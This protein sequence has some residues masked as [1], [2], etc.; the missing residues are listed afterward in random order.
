MCRS[1]ILEEQE[2]VSLLLEGF[3]ER[4][5]PRYQSLL[6]LTPDSAKVLNNT[7]TCHLLLGNF[8][9][10]WEHYSRALRRAPYDADI[11]FNIALIY[12][13]NGEFERGWPLYESRLKKP[14]FVRHGEAFRQTLWM[15]EELNGDRILVHAEQGIGDTLQMVRL[16][17]EVVKRGGRVTL[18]VQPALRSLLENIDGAERVVSYNEKFPKCVWRCSL[19]SLPRRLNW[20]PR[21]AAQVP[22]VGQKFLEKGPRSNA[23]LRVGFV[24][25]GNKE[26]FLNG[27]RSLGSCRLLEPILSVK[28]IHFVSL[29]KGDTAA[30]LDEAH[31]R[32]W[33]I[34][35]PRLESFEDTA[36]IIAGIDLVI[37]VDTSVAHLAGA[38]AKP[39]WILLS[40]PCDWR[41]MRDRMD[42]PWYPTAVLFRQSAAGDWNRPIRRMKE[43]LLRMRDSHAVRLAE[44]LPL[45][46]PVRPRGKVSDAR[47][48]DPWDA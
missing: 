13:T 32:H 36:R 47:E 26:Y 10:A 44:A 39:V 42:S 6:D 28:D 14:E 34:E 17:P 3:P 24:W 29:Q 25:A 5:L 46:D 11:L 16:I 38:M 43:E 27:R 41:W 23:R 30:Q 48:A 35:R 45:P 19:M 2:A 7:G 9:V 40:N 18:L 1:P 21:S 33:T 22:Y 4:A 37:S 15:G 12:L 8:E 20:T 31:S